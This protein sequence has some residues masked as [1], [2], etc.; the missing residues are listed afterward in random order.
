M[1]DIT[2]DKFKLKKK[3]YFAVQ[4]LWFYNCH[5][6]KMT[7]IF[8]GFSYINRFENMCNNTL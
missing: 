2:G 5:V 3:I 6:M 1:S 4:M 7:I 8:L